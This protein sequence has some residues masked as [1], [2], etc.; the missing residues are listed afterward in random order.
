[1]AKAGII[2]R[3][4]F[5]A[6]SSEK[7]SGQVDYI[8]R[9]AAVRNY[10]SDKYSLYNELN[11]EQEKVSEIFT[12]YKTNLT[13]NDKQV[14][15]KS[16]EDAQKNKSVM[17]QPIWSFDGEWLEENGIFNTKTRQLDEYKI[18]EM[19]RAAM[20][21]MLKKEGLADS[22]LWAA[23]IHYNKKHIHIHVAMVEPVPTRPMVE[24]DGVKQPK[25]TFKKSS[26]DAG[27][28]HMANLIMEQKK[29][30]EIINNIMRID[31]VKSDKTEIFND[32]E[33][34][35][36]FFQKDKQ[37]L[38][39]SR[40]VKQGKNSAQLLRLIIPVNILNTLWNWDKRKENS[41]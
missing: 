16:F 8:D 25:G 22:A 17:W 24:F 7:F 41:I 19:T 26:M 21:K 10:T 35:K 20:D 4:K 18:Q 5:V 28:G 30:N 11:F 40:V 23:T 29:S 9:E 34:L 6:S 36:V 3:N 31:I 2:F 37:T 15:K 1:M 12:A 32:K 38:Q 14:L 39:D 13:K 33:L 27:K